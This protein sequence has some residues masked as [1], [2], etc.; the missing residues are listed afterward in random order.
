MDCSG[1]RRG[2]IENPYFKFEII[3][4]AVHDGEPIYRFIRN[5]TV[6]KSSGMGTL[7][8]QEEANHSYGENYDDRSDEEGRIDLILAGD[9]FVQWG[10]H[11]DDVPPFSWP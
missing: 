6:R 5:L 8:G 2:L 9:C 10:V 3:G 4:R 7:F 11:D 1:L